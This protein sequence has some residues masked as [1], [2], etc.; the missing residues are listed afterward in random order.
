MTGE[1]ADLEDD[2]RWQLDDPPGHLLQVIHLVD[3]TW[4][5]LQQSEDLVLLGFALHALQKLILGNLGEE[6]A[7]GLDH[8]EDYLDIAVDV[9]LDPSRVLLEEAVSRVILEVLELFLVS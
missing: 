1:V 3:E 2:V 7:L 8:E 9:D 5:S 6:P 4:H